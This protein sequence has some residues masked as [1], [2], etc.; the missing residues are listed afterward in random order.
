[1][2]YEVAV[3]FLLRCALTPQKDEMRGEGWGRVG[4]IDNIYSPHNHSVSSLQCAV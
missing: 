4:N 3:S 2:V 1:M